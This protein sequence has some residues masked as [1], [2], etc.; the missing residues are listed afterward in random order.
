MSAG[1]LRDAEEG[2]LEEVARI[3]VAAWK[4]AYRGM[5]DDARLDALTPADRLTAWRGWWRGDGVHLRVA[6]AE[7][8]LAGFLRRSPARMIDDPPTDYAEITHLYLDPQQIGTGLG[9]ALLG[10]AL[11]DTRAEG[12]DGALLWTLE[13]NDRARRFYERFGLRTDGAR[14]SQPDWLGEGVFEIRY[15]L[16]FDAESSPSLET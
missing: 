7:R 4:A 10:E 14:Q 16:A 15:L 8:G 13:A 3:H 12:Y 6:D 2:D 1:R 11:R 9:A 5:I